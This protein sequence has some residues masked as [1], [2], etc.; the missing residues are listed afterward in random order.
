MDFLETMKKVYYA[1]SDVTACWLA[2]KLH[3]REAKDIL[4]TAED[5]ITSLEAETEE[6]RK[7]I[8]TKIQNAKSETIRNMLYLQLAELDNVDYTPTAAERG[9]FNKAIV[10]GETAIADGRK[11]FDAFKAAK[12]D[13]EKALKE[14]NGEVNQA[15]FVLACR[16]FEGIE[17][18]FIKRC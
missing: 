12:V 9:A 5:R 4:K 3:N 18:D 13:A 6:K 11:A 2:V 15:D 14:L 10:D 17:E 1:E 8:E 16:W 7:E